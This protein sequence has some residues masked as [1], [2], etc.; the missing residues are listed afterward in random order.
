VVITVKLIDCHT[1]EIIKWIV[2]TP[3]MIAK[4]KTALQRCNAPQEEKNTGDQLQAIT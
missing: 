4:N 3:P 1:K 2:T